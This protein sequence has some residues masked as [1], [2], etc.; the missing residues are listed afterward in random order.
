VQAVNVLG[1]HHRV[2]DQEPDRD[3]E[4]EQRDHVEGLAEEVH[5]DYRHDHR[6]RDREGDDQAHPQPAEEEE[7]HDHREDRPDPAARQEH[8]HRL[9]DDLAR[10]HD[11]VRLDRPEAR[12]RRQLLDHPFD[13]AGHVQRVRLAFLLHADRVRGQAVHPH[14]ELVVGH[15]VAHGGDVAQPHRVGDPHVADVLRRR[16]PRNRPQEQLPGA[17]ADVARRQGE[18]VRLQILGDL[19]DVEARRL[20]PLPVE[21]DQH[22][23][24]HQ[25]LGV[26][27][28]HAGQPLQLQDDLVLDQVVR[29]GSSLV[30]E[31]ADHR[32]RHPGVVVLAD[33]DLLNV[34]RQARPG[35]LDPV[36]DLAVGDVHVRPVREAQEDLAEADGAER[37]LVL[38]A[39]DGRQ[40]LFQRDRDLVQH[41]LGRRVAPRHGH[42]QE[43]RAVTG[44]DQLDRQRQGR[45]Q[46]HDQDRANDH[47]DADAA[48]QGKP[49][50]G[51]AETAGDHGRLPCGATAPAG[52]AASALAV[53]V[54]GRAT[55]VRENDSA[56][57]NRSKIS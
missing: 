48:L 46:P 43:G 16:I 39:A 10:T 40:F 32:H 4:P 6:E 57:R 7:E 28:G 11:H 20:D 1:H 18:V 45:D 9:A 52:P 34:L 8:S 36:P 38:E 30:D 14:P 24:L 26:D 17:C 54:A 56:S 33:E 42:P 5:R 12:I 37:E 27:R 22:F 31:D 19:E 13:L 35:A 49:G 29:V 47:Q 41:L 50:Q 44:W 53:A 51:P 21:L 55:R 23:P 2:V 3:H 25:A 15:V